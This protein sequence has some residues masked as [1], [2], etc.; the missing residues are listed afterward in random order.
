MPL[1]AVALL[2][3]ISRRLWE[4]GR[5]DPFQ[6]L[7]LRGQRLTVCSAAGKT[8]FL[9]TLLL[10]VQLPPSEGG[11]GKSALY[12]STEAPLQT[13][14]LAQILQHHPKL[15]ALPLDERPSLS[16]IQSTH[17]HDVE[18]QEHI[19]RYQVPVAIQ[20]QNIGLVVVDSIAANYRAEFDRTKARKGAESFAKRSHQLTQ[21]GALLN[22][23]A[24]RFG[25]A[26]VVANQV[27]D[28]FTSYDQP[29]PSQA[30]LSTQ[31]TQRSRP[32]SPQQ[33]PPAS[34][35]APMSTNAPSTAPPATAA[36]ILS[37][38]DPLALDHQQR[39]FTG[40][41]DDPTIINLKT[42]SLGLTWTNQL[43]ARIALLKHPLYDDDRVYEAGEDR[44]IAGWRR[45]AKVIFA[46]WCAETQAD[47]EI[48]QGG[49]RGVVLKDGGDV[50]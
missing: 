41:G 38:D 48:W 50:P 9:L 18:A 24:Q 34:L 30:F 21:L 47:F 45:T 26:V 5:I 25:V 11:L 32:H 49:V 33:M 29:P 42:P 27:A 16:R 39:F 17:I 40:W 43:G 2:P 28:R 3:A 22:D 37:T 31:A 4:K 36:P 1:W 7:F 12:I 14:R 10:S 15:S 20:K 46:A 35:S 6:V 13:S 23:I 44:V 19:L 8:Q